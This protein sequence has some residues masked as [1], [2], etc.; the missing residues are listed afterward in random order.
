M[1]DNRTMETL[2]KQYA[3]YISDINPYHNSEML[4]SFDGSLDDYTEYFGEITEKWFIL[5]MKNW[6]YS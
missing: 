1:E 4:E 3:K 2:V 6:W 5:L